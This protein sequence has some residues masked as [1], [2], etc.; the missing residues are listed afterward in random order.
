[1]A[2][3]INSFETIH[4]NGEHLNAKT[5]HLARDFAPPS[6][7]PKRHAFALVREPVLPYIQCWSIQKG[8]MRY[9]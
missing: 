5:L 8:R 2:Q 4:P 3:S 7:L 6:V 1:M 9:A